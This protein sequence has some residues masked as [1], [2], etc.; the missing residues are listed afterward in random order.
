MHFTFYLGQLSQYRDFGYALD[1]PG[2]VPG[3]GKF[4]R[5]PE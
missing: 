5:L 4:F 3:W 2:F 1:D